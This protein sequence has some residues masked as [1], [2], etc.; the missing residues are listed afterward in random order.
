MSRCQLSIV[1]NR[2]L[3]KELDIEL[4]KFEV[5][6]KVVRIAGNE[7]KVGGLG[8]GAGEVGGGTLEV[9]DYS[10]C[11]SHAALPPNIVKTAMQPPGWRRLDAF[12][13]KECSVVAF[14]IPHQILDD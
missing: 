11:F 6:R 14:L 7:R 4:H 3:T 1:Y 2:K 13:I 10:Y 8:R 9:A 5:L 12:C